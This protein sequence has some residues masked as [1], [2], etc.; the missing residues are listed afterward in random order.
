MNPKITPTVFSVSV[1][2]RIT[3]LA[4]CTCASVILISSLYL[5]SEKINHDP[6]GFIR[7]FPPN[8]T[9]PLR[10][11]DIE[12]S[13]H[14]IAGASG[15][16]IYLGNYKV[17]GRLVSTDYSLSDTLHL[18]LK[19]PKGVKLFVGT[20]VTIDSANIYLMD[21]VTRTLLRGKLSDLALEALRDSLDYFIGS[22]PVT[23][24]S[25][26]LKI[27]DNRLKKAVL[28]K[29][30]VNTDSIFRAP[31]ILEKQIDGIFCTDGAINYDPSSASMVYVYAYRNQFIRLDTSL[32]I[33]Y[34]GRT[35]DTT[36]HARIKV[37]YIA[38]SE[39]STYSAPPFFVNK[40]S[41]IN[42]KYVFIQ[43][44]LLAN[45]EVKKTFDHNTVIDVYNIQNGQYKFS[46]YLP[47]YM[48]NKVKSF[49]VFDKTLLAIHDHYLV[50]YRLNF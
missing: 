5:L 45:N 27:Y 32:N 22:M 44:G 28:A 14:Y 8:L 9:T 47:A 20:T 4:V 12:Q 6:N 48:D 18:R 17:L 2:K 29:K 39:K 19:F 43:S 31:Q 7:L 21:G 23:P 50:S 13:T 11:L 36:T 33:L 49:R 30:V 37:G 42:D 24:R 34:R 1:K 25:Y 35:I 40:G 3:L 10:I 38:S 16:R 41:C 46:F 15:D 26:I